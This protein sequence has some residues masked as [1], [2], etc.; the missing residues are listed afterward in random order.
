M[1]YEIAGLPRSGKT[2]ALTMIAQR[3]LKGKSTA[4]IPS[5]DKVFTTFYCKGCYK[6]DF[7]DLKKYDF[8]DC[9][10]LIDEI[11]LF[12]DNRDY[13]SFDKDMIYFFKLHG[14]YKIDLVWC[15]QHFSDADK[16]IRDVTDTI[17]LCEPSVIP[18]VSILKKILHKYN[19][20]NLS[21]EYSLCP[22]SHWIY[23]RRRKYYKYFDSYEKKEKIQLDAEHL[24]EW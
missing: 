3:S 4:G 18:N 21:D 6:L 8:S 9:L 22:R 19:I 16:K 5:H 2:T 23:Y 14:H 17:F 13:R 15:S 10:I 7:D 12:A 24:K 1:I 20:K 11:S